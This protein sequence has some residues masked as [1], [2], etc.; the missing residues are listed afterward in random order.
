MSC[1]CCEQTGHTFAKG[2]EWAEEVL[3]ITG[4][5]TNGKKVTHA[6]PITCYWAA[7][8]EGTTPLA[9]ISSIFTGVGAPTRF[10]V[11]FDVGEMDAIINAAGGTAPF[12]IWRVLAVAGDF[13][14]TRRVRILKSLADVGP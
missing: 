3:P 11:R 10:F 9:G 1:S 5:D 6:G 14:R 7:T 8:E 2:N 12:D 13:R 4:K